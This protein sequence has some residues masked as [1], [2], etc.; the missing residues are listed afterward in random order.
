MPRGEP[1]LH[2]YKSSAQCGMMWFRLVY[3]RYIYHA[4]VPVPIQPPVDKHRELTST[5]SRGIVPTPAMYI[6]LY[7]NIYHN[8]QALTVTR[9]LQNNETQIRLH[10]SYRWPDRRVYQNRFEPIQQ[11]RLVRLVEQMKESK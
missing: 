4:L 3:T 7:P 10:G 1:P 9:S 11:T 6:A 2:E 5:T 8:Q